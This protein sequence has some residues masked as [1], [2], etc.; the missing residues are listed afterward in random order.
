[1]NFVFVING[2]LYKKKMSVCD[3][4]EMFKNFTSI[5]YRPLFRTCVSPKLHAPY[6][7]FKLLQFCT[8][9]VQLTKRDIKEEENKPCIGIKFSKILDQLM[10]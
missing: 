7:P 2:L 10:L 6:T 8:R 3:W 1:M 9:R 4:L 5:C